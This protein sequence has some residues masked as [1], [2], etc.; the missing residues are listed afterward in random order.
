M[1]GGARRVRM[2]VRGRQD[3]GLDEGDGLCVGFGVGFRQN[4]HVGFWQN[5]RPEHGYLLAAALDQAVA[6]P[7]V[8]L[9]LRLAL[10]PSPLSSK[11]GTGD[12]EFAALAQPG[13]RLFIRERTKRGSK[14][15]QTIL[16]LHTKIFSV[17][18]TR[19][20]DGAAW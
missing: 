16:I 18:K 19:M 11:L 4:R 9:A 5:R 6:F 20:M 8:K 12:G 15:R 7:V 1:R 2:G 14:S 10:A 3:L 13:E 17:R